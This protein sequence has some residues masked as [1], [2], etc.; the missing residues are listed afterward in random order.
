M[1]TLFNGSGGEWTARILRI[2][3]SEVAVEVGAHDAADREL[4]AAVTLALG[5]PANERMDTLI[6]KATELGVAAI[7]PLQCERSVLRLSGE[8][9]RKKVEH[10]R[11]PLSVGTAD[12]E[13][14]P[15]GDAGLTGMNRGV[16]LPAGAAG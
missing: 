12:H 7:Q 15:A 10:W 1:L 9:S 16:P 8:R 2:G 14:A 6:E 11:G 5:M 13:S 4:Q 3:R